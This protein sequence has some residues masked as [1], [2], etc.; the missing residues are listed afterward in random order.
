MV[1]GLYVGLGILSF[2]LVLNGFLQGAKKGQIMTVLSL[3]II[4]IVI[5]LFIVAGW[6]HAGFAIMFAFLV[7]IGTRPVAAR[8]ASRVFSKLS[9]ED[10]KY[11]GLPPR[12]LQIISKKLGR[13][14]EPRKIL[15]EEILKE[16]DKKEV[17][18]EE[19]LF[20]YC[21]NQPS[22]KALLREFDISRNDLESLYHKLI[23]A[24]AG[25]WACGHWVAAS[26]LAYPESLRYVI[27][28]GEDNITRTVCNLIV[29]F[30]RGSI[31]NHTNE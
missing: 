29:Y 6:K 17:R 5:T 31:L 27:N 25:Q 2:L 14:I 1:P 24:G 10:G 20:D 18:P 23:M 19:L 15:Y 21:E 22:T 28:R 30:E 9:G 13:P 12:D 26:A 3:L 16:E 8:I 11:V 4:G 7:G